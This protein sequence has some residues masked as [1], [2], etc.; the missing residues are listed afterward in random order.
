MQGAVLGDGLADWSTIVNIARAI[1]T[2][3][4]VATIMKIG[5][6]MAAITVAK[7]LSELLRHTMRC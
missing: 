5:A 4:D 1:I 2:L 3:H 6:S 7:M